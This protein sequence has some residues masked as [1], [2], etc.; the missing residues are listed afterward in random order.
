LDFEIRWNST[1]TTANG[2]WRYPGDTLINN[3]GRKVVICP[4]RVVN[5]TDTLKFRAL[6]ANAGSDSMWRPGREIAN[7]YSCESRAKLHGY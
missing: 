7:C 4:F 3:L 2:K 1:D 5:V 6:V